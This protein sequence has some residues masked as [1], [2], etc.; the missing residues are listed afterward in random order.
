MIILTVIARAQ[1]GSANEH[2]HK[3]TG[4]H[5]FHKYLVCACY[6]GESWNHRICSM[7]SHALCG[8][9]TH[10]LPPTELHFIV[11]DVAAFSHLSMQVCPQKLSLHGKSN[12]N[13]A[14]EH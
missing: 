1:S 9:I 4:P 12:T 10:T 6:H 13:K 11:T 14:R 7:H 2:K 8:L 3:C 5:F